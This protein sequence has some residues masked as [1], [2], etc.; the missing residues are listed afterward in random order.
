MPVP[1]QTPTNITAT[2]P[3]RRRNM[4][5]NRRRDTG[6]ERALRSALHAAGYRYRCDLRID[7]AETRVRPDVVFTRKKVAVFVD[8]CFWHSCPVHG[9]QPRTNSE[10]WSPKLQ[11]NRERDCRNT[12]ALKQAGW[13]VVRVWEHEPVDEAIDKVVTALELS[14]NG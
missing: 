5:A 2:T 9:R 11:K 1:S 14:A 6:P 13:L 7:L 8:G 3:G 12:E 4:Q 10:Y